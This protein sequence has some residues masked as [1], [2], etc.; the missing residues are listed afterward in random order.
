MSDSEKKWE[1]VDSFWG[2]RCTYCLKI[3]KQ[4]ERTLDH[5][6]PINKGGS[7]RKFNLVPA[8]RSC[9][10]TKDD[11]HPNYFCTKV[12]AD[13]VARYMNFLI[14]G[15]VTNLNRPYYS[16]DKEYTFYLRSRQSFVSSIRLVK[17][18]HQQP[19]NIGS[20]Y[21]KEKGYWL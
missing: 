10:H 2:G 8:C 19:P 14:L 5:F 1:R 18:P 9:N 7:G 11:Y 21:E 3:I 6:I 20:I 12:Q 16:M 13:H 15:V 4:F 17:M